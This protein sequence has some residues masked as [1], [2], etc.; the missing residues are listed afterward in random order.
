VDNDERVETL[1]RSI[2]KRYEE[3]N[4]VFFNSLDEFRLPD[5]V[6]VLLTEVIE[7]NSVND[8][9]ALIRRALALNFNKLFITTPNVEFNRFYSMIGKFRHEDHIFEPSAAEFRA[10][11]EECI[12]GQGFHVEYFYLGDTVNGIQPTQGVIIENGELKIEN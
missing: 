8:A 5:K 2:A 6:N 11:I 7:H 1:S 12:A 10:M 3:N 4:R 9:K